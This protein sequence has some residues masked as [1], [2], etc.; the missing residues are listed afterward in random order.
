MNDIFKEAFDNIKAEPQLKDNTYDYLQNEILKRKQKSRLIHFPKFIYA[1]TTCIILFIFGVKGYLVYFEEISF[2]TIDVN[3]SIELSLNRFD[4]VISVEAYNDEGTKIL[5]SVNVK[6]KIYNNALEIL[7]KDELLSKYINNNSYISF[8]VQSSDTKKESLLL[9]GVQHCG[10]NFIVANNQQAYI[11][12]SAVDKELR[13]QAHH[14]GI[15]VGK[16]QAIL[17]LQE[18]NPNAT[19]EEYK[20]NTIKELKI[21]TNNCKQNMNSHSNGNRNRGCRNRHH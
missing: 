14:Y 3:P 15:S 2:V 19:I 18:V 20:N 6:N 1:A 10:N 16:Y 8:T 5:N 4:R 9:S 7:I 17:E 13:Q 11:E 12:Y 21:E